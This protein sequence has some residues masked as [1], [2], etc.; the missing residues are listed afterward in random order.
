M[1][2][3]RW[4]R[5]KNT[6]TDKDGHSMTELAQ[7]TDSVKLTLPLESKHGIYKGCTSLTVYPQYFFEGQHQVLCI[8]ICFSDVL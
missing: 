7:R 5:Q 6:Q 1:G 8:A 2:V 4:R 3:L